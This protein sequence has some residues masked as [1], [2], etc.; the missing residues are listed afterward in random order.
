MMGFNIILTQIIMLGIMMLLGFI[1]VKAKYIDVNLK[2]GIS[3]VIIKFTLPLLNLTAITGQ[4]MRPEMLR[5][6]AILILVEA[7]VVTLM[8]LVGFLTSKLFRLPPATHTIHTIMSTFGNVAFLG[9][10][11]I[12]ALF[13]QEGLFY[14]IVYTLINDGFLWTAGV[15]LIAKSG[16]RDATASFKKLINPNTVTFII[17]II[18]LVFGIKLPSLLHETL[19]SVGSMTT[20][21]AMLFIGIT[22]GSIPLRGIYKKISIY[23]I[24]LIKMLI[25]PMVL[26]FVLSFFPIDQIL[27][28]V[29]VL[30][31]ATPVQ[32]IV[33][34]MAGNLGSDYQYAAEC[35]F[36]TTIASLVTLPAMYWFIL[37][38]I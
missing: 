29:L 36:I 9:Y 37:Q 10:P 11:L 25:I 22:L 7:L 34:V 17:A 21:L 26:T 4:D 2:N 27:L 19:A 32:T 38:I 15:V 16:G 23:F 13:G 24:I 28:C 3:Q 14:A 8:Y 18:M 20:C 6:A 30:Q 1:G 35:V 5:N 12:T 33:T 31:V